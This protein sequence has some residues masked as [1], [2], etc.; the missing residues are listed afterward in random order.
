MDL[1]WSFYYNK[2]IIK[3]PQTLVKEGHGKD[4]MV[5]RHG[6]L[7]LILLAGCASQAKEERIESLRQQVRGLQES[8]ARL[9]ARVEELHNKLTFLEDRIE[10]HQ[11]AIENLQRMAL[12]T[13]P[14]QGLK[15][16]RIEPGTEDPETLYKRG[17]N[18]YRAGN[19]TEAREVFQEFIRKFPHHPL[20]DNALYWIG[21]TYY[22]ERDYGKAL[23][24]FRQVARDYPQGNKVP[25]ALLKVALTLREM[26]RVRESREVL[27]KLIED[28]P[29]SEAALKGS[30]LLEER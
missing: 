11:E 6:I 21:E 24:I 3:G 17:Y 16:V 14:P 2:T 5:G 20:G 1:T 19:L 26:G 22:T 9:E 12:P 28:Y 30:S 29:S 27:K 18:L 10:A 25:D 4:R 8:Q 7:L 13:E 23:E 15:E